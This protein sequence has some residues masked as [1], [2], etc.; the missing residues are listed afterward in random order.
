MANRQ[1]VVA[2]FQN[3]QN[4]LTRSQVEVH[5][6]ERLRHRVEYRLRNRAWKNHPIAFLHRFQSLQEK[7]TG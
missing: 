7:S 3:Q 6:R 4:N 5:G 1:R 2:R